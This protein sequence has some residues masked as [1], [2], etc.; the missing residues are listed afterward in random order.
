MMANI[1]QELNRN[2][3]TC[4]IDD[5]LSLSSNEESED[6]D[7]I[8]G[9]INEIQRLKNCFA[10]RATENS[11]LGHAIEFPLAVI[12][13]HGNKPLRVVQHQDE[14]SSLG[15]NKYTV[16]L[17]TENDVEETSDLSSDFDDFP[18]IARTNSGGVT[19][20]DDIGVRL[21]GEFQFLFI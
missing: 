2:I 16:D 15:K 20:Q 7:S 17:M 8:D 10:F 19:F 4:D 5:E 13:T 12:P 21:D 6:D 9:L 11:F 14:T 3:E 18:P 1:H